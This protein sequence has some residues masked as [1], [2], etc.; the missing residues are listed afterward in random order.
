MFNIGNRPLH[1]GICVP[2]MGA[3]LTETALSIAAMAIVNENNGIYQSIFNQQQASVSCCRNLIAKDA[4]QAD[5]DYT[6]WIDADMAFNPDLALRLLKHEKDIVGAT[7]PQRM[8]PY[9]T[10]GRFPKGFGPGLAP[11]DFMPFGAMLVKTEVFKKLPRP[12]FFESYKFDGTPAEQLTRALNSAANITLD[13]KFLDEMTD[14]INR[15]YPIAGDG[16][17]RP[18]AIRG[19]D[20]NFCREAI[21]H[22][23]T[24]WCDTDL[25]RAMIHIGKQCVSLGGALPGLPTEVVTPE[26]STDNH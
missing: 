26:L 13:P 17:D 19:E 24:V 14:L 1:L 23:Y 3:H 9:V 16:I 22:G 20:A 4:V 15:F 25:S 5:T 2:S 11:A 12:W 21:R 18:T 8:P 10:N 6:L 7:Y